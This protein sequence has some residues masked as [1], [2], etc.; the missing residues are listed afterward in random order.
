[1]LNQRIFSCAL[2]AMSCVV[3][4]FAAHGSYAADPAQIVDHLYLSSVIPAQNKELLKEIG[5]R[6][7]LN[8]TGPK[9]GSDELRYPNFFPEDFHYLQIPIRDEQGVQ[10]H[11]FFDEA[12]QFINR[13][14][15]RNEKVLVHCE[16]GI[17]R[18]A[19]IVISYLM[20]FNHMTLKAALSHVQTK[21]R[22]VGPNNDF[23]SQLLAFEMDL[24]RQGL[25]DPKSIPS[26]TLTEYLVQQMLSG[27]AMGFSQEQ[28]EQA[29]KTSKNNPDLALH[30]LFSAGDDY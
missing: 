22:N 14:I 2:F 26:M 20:K 21:K 11:Q 28:V 23:F 15:L 24:G 10:I 29:L 3:S 30:I 16:A 12:H 17:S 7:V 8:M 27:P 18:S 4:S 5:I 6:N 13:G 9:K 1:M 19:T 25:L